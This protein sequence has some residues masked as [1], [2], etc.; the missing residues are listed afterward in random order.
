MLEI[1]FSAKSKNKWLE[2]TFIGILCFKIR[3]EEMGKT[4]CN[5]AVTF[6]FIHRNR[7]TI[8]LELCQ[9]ARRQ[10]T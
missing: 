8:E 4:D 10:K 1:H 2:L 3:I 6:G 7:K 9:F 5:F